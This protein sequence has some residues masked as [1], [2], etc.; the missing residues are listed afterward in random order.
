MR[1]MLLLPIFILFSS[2]G[3]DGPEVPSEATVLSYDGENLNAPTFPPGLYEFAARFP[4]TLTRELEGQSLTQVSFFMYDAPAA[5]Y[6]N[7][8]TDETTT[9]PGPILNSQ[10][11]NNPT[12]NSWNTITLNTPYLIDGTSLW[13]G[14]EVTLDVEQQSVGCD[15]GPAFPNGDWL[16]DEENLTWVT[17]TNRTGSAESVNWNIKAIIE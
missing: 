12:P 6:I 2:C 13:V 5:M 17:F 14:V 1:W 9:V 8:S 15:A 10:R 16:Y 3:D 4:S 11:V 7:I